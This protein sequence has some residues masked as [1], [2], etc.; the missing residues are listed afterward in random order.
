MKDL[1]NTITL[2]ETPSITGMNADGTPVIECAP[3]EQ[4]NEMLSR[5]ED[6][7]S[8]GTLPLPRAAQP[9]APGRVKV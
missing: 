5:I 1:L 6:A 3:P 2:T 9:S 7:I 4:V 8:G